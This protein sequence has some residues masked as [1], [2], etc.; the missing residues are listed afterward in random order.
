MNPGRVAAI[1]LLPVGAN[2]TN[3]SEIPLLQR[4]RA[5]KKCSRSIER[6]GR[7]WSDGTRTGPT[8]RLR[9]MLE[10]LM[11]AATP[12]LEEG[13]IGRFVKLAPMAL[14]GGIRLNKI[15]SAVGTTDAFRRSAAG[16]EIIYKNFRP[17]VGS[18]NVRVSFCIS[19]STSAMYSARAW[20]FV[21]RFRP[22]SM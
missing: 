8:T 5:I 19:G 20:E 13:N 11:R 15:Q 16:M 12:P 21:R 6:R 2:L 18:G 22:H 4:R 9:A 17:A 1:F 7:G 3:R 14:A 10:T